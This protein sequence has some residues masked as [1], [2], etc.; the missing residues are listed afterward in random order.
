M[1]KCTKVAYKTYRQAR[2]ATVHILKGGKLM[3]VYQ[4]HDCGKF[5][6]TSWY[7]NK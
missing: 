2:Y 5:H 3:R 6:L 7:L 4:C 1:I